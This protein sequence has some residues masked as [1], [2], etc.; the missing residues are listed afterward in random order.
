LTKA[1]W[2][3]E[4]TRNLHRIFGFLYNPPLDAVTITGHYDF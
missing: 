2:K 4:G 3:K 1:P